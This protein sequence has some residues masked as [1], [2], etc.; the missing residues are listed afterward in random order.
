[1]GLSS[2]LTP[3]QDL[4]QKLGLAT[5]DEDKDEMV[6]DGSPEHVEKVLSF[7]EKKNKLDWYKL[8]MRGY[9]RNAQYNEYHIDVTQI[10]VSKERFEHTITTGM[11]SLSD[12]TKYI[13]CMLDYLEKT[14]IAPTKEQ[15]KI[16]F[17][18]YDRPFYQKYI[19]E[20]TKGHQPIAL[21][22]DVKLG[23]INLNTMDAT[24]RN[25]ILDWAD[26]AAPMF[27]KLSPLKKMKTAISFVR[28]GYD[29][30]DVINIAIPFLQKYFM[31]LLELDDQAGITDLV[32]NVI[33]KNIRDEAPKFCKYVKIALDKFPN[34]QKSYP[35]NLPRW[36]SC[37]KGQKHLSKFDFISREDRWG[38]HI[39]KVK[40]HFGVCDK[41][42]NIIIEPTYVSMGIPNEKEQRLAI[43]GKYGSTLV[44]FNQKGE[45]IQEA[46]RHQSEE[47]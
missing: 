25:K 31:Q 21:D 18:K 1:M 29:N 39:V 15:A 43:G 5:W 13:P 44:K 36:R 40:N 20:V 37:L 14:G 26:D 42:G 41:K 22:L 34:L 33:Q 23:Y 16:F 10:P 27:Q 9:F 32:L 19:A 11:M 30:Y 47:S 17:L 7:L 3:F 38:Q 12:L 2:S 28:D 24:T 4:Q 6:E 35:F 45:I 46:P 8:L